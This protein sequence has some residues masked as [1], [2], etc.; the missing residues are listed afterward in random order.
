MAVNDCAL[1]LEKQRRIDDL[2]EEV[3]RLRAALWREQRKAQDGLFGSSTPSSKKPVKKNIE[4]GEGKPKGARPGHKGHGRKGHE[5]GM[6]DLMVDIV[7][8][9]ELCPQCGN[10]LLKKGVEE[11]SVLDTPSQKPARVTFNLH[12]RYCP[13]CRKSFMPQPPGVLPKSLFGN[14]L[15]AN[16]ITMH[17]LHGVPMERICENLVLVAVV[18]RGCFNDAPDCL[19]MCPGSSS[20]NTDRLLPSMQTR[21]VG[22]RTGKTDTSGFLPLVI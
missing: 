4:K 13:H 6:S 18:L 1:C 20:R 16:A 3:R 19:K 17:Y 22:V 12:K 2:E 9:S 14:Q 5:E 8:D 21:L 11:R 7:P 10:T 15:I